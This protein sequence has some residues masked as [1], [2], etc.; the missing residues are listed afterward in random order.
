MTKEKIVKQPEESPA[1]EG[2][3][4]QPKPEPP[5][6]VSKWQQYDNYECVQCPFS[7]LSE[8]EMLKHVTAAHPIIV[9]RKLLPY[10]YMTGSAT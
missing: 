3:T 6:R 1:P 8:N 5:Y 7:T 10:R 9:P 2:T 4:E